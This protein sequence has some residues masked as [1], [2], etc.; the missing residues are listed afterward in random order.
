MN[1]ELRAATKI[2]D[3]YR[4]AI[5]L[6]TQL[7]ADMLRPMEDSRE[8]EVWGERSVEISEDLLRTIESI[9]FEYLGKHV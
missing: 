4:N 9:T 6:Y 1:P 3:A 8:T 7:I 2:A 5:V